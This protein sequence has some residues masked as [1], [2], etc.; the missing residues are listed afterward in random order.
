VADCNAL[1]FGCKLKEGAKDGANNVIV[2]VAQ[3]WYDA[4]KKLIEWF[5]SFWI[6]TPGP[7][8]DSPA[9]ALLTGKLGWYTG[10]FAIVG[11]LFAL[12]RTVI[13]QDI[14][15]LTVEGLRPIVNL[16]IVTGT[17]TVGLT[18]LMQ[19][20]D[21]FSVWIIEKAQGSGNGELEAGFMLGLLSSP[22]LLG[23]GTFLIV[24]LLLLIASIINVAF[25]LFRN[26]VMVCLLVLLP[27][28]GAASGTETG[29]QAFKKANGWLLAFLL[30]KPVAALIFALGLA[31]MKD[32]IK[33]GQ[34]VEETTQSLVTAI[35]GILILCVAALA[36]PALVKFLVPV[37][38]YGSGGFSG[39]A[40]IGAGASVAAGAAVIAASGGTAAAAGGGAA[41]SGGGAAASG[42]AGGA[43]AG[44]ASTAASGGGGG[45]GGAAASGGAEAGGGGGAG[46]ASA[47]SGGTSS[48]GSGTEAGESASGSSSG[49]ESASS[50]SGESSTSSDSSSAAGGSSTTSGA[51]S[52][53]SSAGTGSETATSGAGPESATPG[54]GSSSAAAEGSSSSSTTSSSGNTLDA[55]NTAATAQGASENLK[56]D[57]DDDDL[58]RDTRS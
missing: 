43:T 11:L 58:E 50:S 55:A 47:G 24:A 23:G 52:S 1:D 21:E 20:G 8:F 9:I 37:A 39:G 12:G 18:A 2:D 25:M 33:T 35:T 34:T 7:D 16:I 45:A 32:P 22:G 27:T 10:A 49:A 26:V 57:L 29:N 40:A 19:A 41:A 42:G 30:F 3:G 54:T 13:T 38:A 6:H 17:Y 44:G 53:E 28:L 51:N 15:T 14:K 4:C 48:A 46:A 36:L 5:G 31:L 56:V